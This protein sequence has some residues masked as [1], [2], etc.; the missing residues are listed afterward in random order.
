MKEQLTANIA[1]QLCFRKTAIEPSREKSWIT[2]VPYLILQSI[3]DVLVTTGF[4]LDFETDHGEVLDLHLVQFE[5]GRQESG[6][7]VARY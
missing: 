3:L 4:G 2:C 5:L 1:V 7:P 6:R